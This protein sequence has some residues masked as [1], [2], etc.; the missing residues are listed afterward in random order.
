MACEAI[1]R[2]ACPLNGPT[3]IARAHRRLC[4]STASC[5]RSMTPGVVRPCHA[6]ALIPPVSPPSPCPVPPCPVPPCPIPHTP[7]P[8]PSCPM[9]GL[10]TAAVP[11]LPPLPPHIPL[12][13]LL[14]RLPKYG[15]VQR[16]PPVQWGAS[17]ALH[18]HDTLLLWSVR[19]LNRV[20]PSPSPSPS[21]HPK[22]ASRTGVSTHQRDA[23]LRTTPSEW[24]SAGDPPVRRRARRPRPARGPPLWRD[25]PPPPR[26]VS[27][28]AAALSLGLRPQP[29]TGVTS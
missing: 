22:Q 4:C 2:S 19:T 21:P 11:V 23:S 28:A 27:A 8:I 13:R 14:P 17:N 12:P 9:G 24:G 25:P 3:E 18:T 6:H 15:G 5:T 1:P 26:R 7:C 29:S 10:L 20:H 16:A